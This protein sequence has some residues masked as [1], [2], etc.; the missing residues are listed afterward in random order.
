MLARLLL[1]T[2]ASGMIGSPA[3]AQSLKIAGTAGYLSEWQVTGTV[4]A[5][6]NEFVGPLSW[7]H[8]GLCSVNGPQEKSGTIRFRLSRLRSSVRINATLSFGNGQCVYNGE[9]AGSSQGFMDCA[10]DSHVPLLI[11]ISD[12]Q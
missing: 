9:F 5:D 2:V 10:D 3:Q 8:V 12:R 4:S 6:H 1:V 7:K 11:S